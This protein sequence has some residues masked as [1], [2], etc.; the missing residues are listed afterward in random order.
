MLLF[1]L[2]GTYEIIWI[3]IFRMFIFFKQ[4]NLK[5]YKLNY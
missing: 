3:L 4:F 1:K 2:I 5:T